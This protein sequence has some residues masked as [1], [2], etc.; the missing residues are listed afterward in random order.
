MD[1]DQDVDEAAGRLVD[2][3]RRAVRYLPADESVEAGRIVGDALKAVERFRVNSSTRTLALDVIRSASTTL[4]RMA[5][6]DA[7]VGSD[8][9]DGQS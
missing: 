5:R 9:D 6:S 7:P 3:Y 2:F 8:P 4:G 1:A